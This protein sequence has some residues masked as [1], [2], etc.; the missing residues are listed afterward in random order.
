M[1]IRVKVIVGKY[2]KTVMV[3]HCTMEIVL[4]IKYKQYKFVIL[5]NVSIRTWTDINKIFYCVF[6]FFYLPCNP[7]IKDTKNI[8]HLQIWVLSLECFLCIEIIWKFYENS[9]QMLEDT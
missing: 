5:F 8:K 1:T 9:M 3:K 7:I 6:L 4:S 2:M